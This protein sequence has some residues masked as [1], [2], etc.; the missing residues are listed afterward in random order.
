MGPISG[1]GDSFFWGILRVIAAGIGISIASTGSPLGAIVFLAPEEGITDPRDR[2]HQGSLN[3]G[4]GAVIEGWVF[5]VLFFHGGYQP[6]DEVVDMHG[7]IEPSG[8]AD[9]GLN[10]TQ[11]VSCTPCY[12]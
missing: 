8:M 12:Q 7:G 5:T 6:H 9:Q 4:D 11:S 10:T 3:G 1:I 2:A